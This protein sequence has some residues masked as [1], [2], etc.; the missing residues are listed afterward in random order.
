MNTEEKIRKVKNILKGKKIII[1]FSG[2]ADSVLIGHI[3]KEVSEEIIAVTF[4]NGLM[5]SNFSNE[6]KKIAENIGIEH[7][8]IEEDLLENTKFSENR[9]N[10]CFICRNLMYNEIKK[11]ADEN[12]IAIIVDGT[13]IDDLMD[14]RPGIIV[15]YDV[16]VVSPFVK[17]GLE[18]NEII[19]YLKK[20]NIDYITST[21]CF[22]TR[23]EKNSKITSRKINMIKYGENLLKSILKT[24][25]LRVRLVLDDM[26]LIE[27]VNIDPILNKNS[28]VHITSELK[29]VKFK[30]VA[31][32]VEPQIKKKKEL[33]YKPCKDEANKLMF[34]ND[35]PYKI[36]IKKTCE[37]LKKIGEI[38]CSNE[39]GVIM[40][41]I[42]GRN[43][44]LFGKGKL[45]AR[46][47][48]DKEDVQDLLI[49]VLPLIRPEIQAEK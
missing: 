38:K 23:I 33:I 32:N 45:V 1:A 9:E 41:D 28:L 18:K 39:M 10:K 2:G 11:I 37:E 7:I 40:L 3:A 30:K 25:E 31:L 5:P 44:T 29:S 26:A 19:E 47:I 24:D 12:N 13:N 34:E 46:K 49:K 17:V 48:K 21:T 22:A 8:L 20:N 16:G 14:N 36:D 6:V 27:L 15:N 4:D 42:D 43:L 35:L